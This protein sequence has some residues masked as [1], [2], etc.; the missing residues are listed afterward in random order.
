[1]IILGSALAVAV[2]VV[3][4]GG[5]GGDTS[6][7][8][9]GSTSAASGSTGATTTGGSSGEGGSN[10]SSGEGGSNASSKPLTKKEFLT[11]GDT[12]CGK[13]P[14]TYNSK[15]QKLEKEAGKPLSKAES[16][17]KAAIP[18]LP[19]AAEELAELTPPKGDEQEVEAIVAAL[20]AATKGLEEKPS[21][22]LSGPQSPFAEFQKLTGEYGFRVCTEL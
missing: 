21:S 6:G 16:N 2:L 11:Q 13:V 19:V 4:C 3:G 7:G 10:A 17:L 15:L 14:A 1:M 5:G 18:P 22:E 8:T 20:E 9:N 12:I